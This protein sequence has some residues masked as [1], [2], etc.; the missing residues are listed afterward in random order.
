MDI[1]NNS[2]GNITIESLYANWVATPSS[3]RL[4][5]IFL[6][7][8]SVWNTSDP[9]PPSN[10]PDEGNWQSSGNLSI[11]NGATQSL[12]IRF[13]DPLQTTGYE[14]RITFNNNCYVSG[15]K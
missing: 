13:G 5:R 3:Q 11:P 4:D 14:V 2:G 1:S 7:G 12:L 9:A 15:T 6:N 10:I 8:I